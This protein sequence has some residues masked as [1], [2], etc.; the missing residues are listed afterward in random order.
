MANPQSIRIGVTGASGFIGSHLVA[1]LKEY[2]KVILLPR[3]KSLPTTTQLKKFV[4]GAELF[5]HLGG[6]NRG[7]EEEILTGNVSGT[8]QLLEAIQEFGKPSARIIFASSSQVYSLK[9]SAGK[10]SES[11]TIEPESVYGICKKS[12]EDLIR[13]S[14]IPHT[15][16]RLANVY[17]PGCRPDYNSVVATLCHRAKKNLPLQING[18]G[19]QGRDFVY[20]DDVVRAFLLAGFQEKSLMGKVY[21]I[22][23]GQITTLKKI[24]TAI[25]RIEKG[26]KVEYK[27]GAED[28]IS[29]CCDSSRFQQDYGWKP[30]TSLSKGIEQT[31][32]HFET[33]KK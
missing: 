9:N 26:I 32:N 17:G 33:G 22:S 13:M 2:G 19:N 11:S 23:S 21:N 7:T 10:I 14:D 1:A 15:I 28:N 5:F 4:T 18:Q 29:Y 25:K 20:I 31:L 8:L 27:P 24:V 6:V 3:G 16:L 12:A 30:K